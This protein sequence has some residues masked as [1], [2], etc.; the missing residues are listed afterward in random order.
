MY[1]FYF[2]A[3]S[4]GISYYYLCHVSIYLFFF[5][6]VVSGTTQEVTGRFG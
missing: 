6:M 2:A 1:V 5:C 3:A 4:I